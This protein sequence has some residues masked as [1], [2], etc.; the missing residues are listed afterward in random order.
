MGVASMISAKPGFAS[1]LVVNALSM[2][3]LDFNN[4]SEV[5]SWAQNPI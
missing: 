2:L 5:Q 1:H 4:Q 3:V